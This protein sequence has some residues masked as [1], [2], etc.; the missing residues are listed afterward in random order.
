M[1][2]GVRV[3]AASSSS[4]EVA[5]VVITILLD[6]RTTPLAVGDEKLQKLIPRHFLLFFILVSD[7]IEIVLAA[8]DPTSEDTLAW[9][10][11]PHLDGRSG[12]RSRK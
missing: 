5:A 10:L 8:N 7:Q 12:A 1:D 3:K 9:P 6:L 2:F 4:S 11:L